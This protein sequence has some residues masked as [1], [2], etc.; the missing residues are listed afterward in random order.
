MQGPLYVCFG[1]N[2]KLGV[3]DMC[4]ISEKAKLESGQNF[5]KN[6]VMKIYQVTSMHNQ[7]IPHSQVGPKSLFGPSSSSAYQ[8]KF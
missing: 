1:F 4:Y 3:W 8:I 7:V 6:C 2:H 5:Q